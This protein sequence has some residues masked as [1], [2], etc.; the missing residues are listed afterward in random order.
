VNERLPSSSQSFDSYVV[1]STTFAYQNDSFARER[2]TIKYSS[3][4]T[5][6]DGYFLS[7]DIGGF[8]MS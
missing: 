6:K 3:V 1:I 4:H 7:G 8:N 2:H 5:S